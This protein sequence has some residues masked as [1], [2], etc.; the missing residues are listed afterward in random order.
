MR[1]GANRT[2]SVPGLKARP[3]SAIRL[4]SRFHSPSVIFSTAAS[5][6]SSLIRVISRRRAKS[7]PSWAARRSNAWMSLGKQYPPYP[8]PAS[9]NALPIRGSEPMMSATDTTSAPARSHTL[10]SALAKETLRARKALLACLASSAVFT[11][12]SM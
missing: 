5:M 1:G 11:S 4:S 7:Y 8:N 12:V 6:A 9:R 2:S 3:N 10:A